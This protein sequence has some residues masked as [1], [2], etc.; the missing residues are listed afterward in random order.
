MIATKYGWKVGVEEKVREI[1]SVRQLVSELVELKITRKSQSQLTEKSIISVW[2][3]K[4][5]DAVEVEAEG[6]ENFDIR[7]LHQQ[8]LVHFP[9]ILQVRHA[10]GIG[11]LFVANSIEWIQ[12]L[13]NENTVTLFE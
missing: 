8:F 9:G 1:K 3:E 5:F 10:N 4:L 13:E 2:T 12:N 11:S 6:K 7:P